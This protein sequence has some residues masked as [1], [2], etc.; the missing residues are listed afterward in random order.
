MVTA[1]EEG[2]CTHDNVMDNHAKFTSERSSTPVNRWMI[3]RHVNRPQM[4]TVRAE[5]L[6]LTPVIQDGALKEERPKSCESLKH[7]MDNNTLEEEQSPTL[8]RDDAQGPP[9]IDSK[10]VRAPASSSP[11]VDSDGD[12]TSESDQRQSRRHRR[13]KTRSQHE[14]SGRTTARSTADDEMPLRRSKRATAGRNP[15]PHNLPRSAALR[16]TELTVPPSF[17]ELSKAMLNLGSMVQS[18]WLQAQVPTSNHK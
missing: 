3:L 6:P 12:S 16:M 10:P 4:P 18:A 8:V 5:T 11:S 2:P 7:A 1:P 9:S 13:V 17:Q 14:R 15:N